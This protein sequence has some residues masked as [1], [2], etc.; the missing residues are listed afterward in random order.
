[1]ASG[2]P[3]IVTRSESDT[4]DSHTT[5]PEFLS[6]AM[7]RAGALAGEMTRL[8]HRAAP[9]LATVRSCLGSVRQTMRPT[10]PGQCHSNGA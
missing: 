9:R 3:V 8:P 6:V 1:M 10:F 7:M 4:L 5:L 2:A